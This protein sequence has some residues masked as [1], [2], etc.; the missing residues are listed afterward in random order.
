MINRSIQL[1]KIIASYDPMTMQQVEEEFLHGGPPGVS[2]SGAETS[3]DGRAAWC[4]RQ[5]EHL[6]RAESSYA[7]LA[8][9]RWASPSKPR[10]RLKSATG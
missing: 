1:R 4:G 2:L 6:Q 7:M 10:P 5:A 3:I 9:T 8:T